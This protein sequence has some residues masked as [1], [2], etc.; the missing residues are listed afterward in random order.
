VGSLGPPRTSLRRSLFLS[1]GTLG[2]GE[3]EV[4]LVFVGVSGVSGVSGEELEE[5][6]ELDELDELEESEESDESD[7]LEEGVKVEG[8]KR[9]VSVVIK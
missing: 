3:L 5:F 2:L 6:S 4:V 8:P 1:Q 7:E 9:L